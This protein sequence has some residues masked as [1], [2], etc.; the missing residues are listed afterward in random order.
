MRKIRIK[1][2]Y[3]PSG[4]YVEGSEIQMKYPLAHLAVQLVRE[5]DEDAL[6]NIGVIGDLP[7]GGPYGSYS[8]GENVHSIPQEVAE[9]VRL[10]FNTDNIDL[11]PKSTL[12]QAVPEMNEQSIQIGDT[13]RVNIDRIIQESQHPNPIIFH[14]NV[15]KEIAKTIYHEATHVHEVETTGETSEPSAEQA[16]TP[17]GNFIEGN[18][19][20][21]AQQIQ[22]ELGLS[23]DEV[24]SYYQ[25][26]E[27][28]QEQ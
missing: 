1:S 3:I 23:D 13:I 16:E 27:D 11:I 12:L 24:A 6:Y 8:T 28:I 21:I 10:V 22:A 7:M 18:F 15:I 5:Y 9:K 19:E 20:R 14:F 2:Q 25:Q 26:D 17:L 4:S